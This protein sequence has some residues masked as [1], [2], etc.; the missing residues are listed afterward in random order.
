M[1]AKVKNFK[2]ATAYAINIVHCSQT[3][4]I[5]IINKASKANLNKYVIASIFSP[6]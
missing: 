5:K 1:A 4:M 2:V 6:K 3:L